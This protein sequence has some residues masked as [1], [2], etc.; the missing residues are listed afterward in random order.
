[1]CGRDLAP[2]ELINHPRPSDHRRCLDCLRIPS[3]HNSS[4]FLQTI[5][6]PLLL[7]FASLLWRLP[8]RHLP[9]LTSPLARSGTPSALHTPP[10]HADS[11]SPYL[12]P[13][14]PTL[15]HGHRN[16]RSTLSFLVLASDG[17]KTLIRSLLYPHTRL[18]QAEQFPHHPPRFP[19]SRCT[20]VVS[21]LR[22]T[23]PCSSSV[24]CISYVSDCT[25]CYRSALPPPNC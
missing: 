25:V 14:P 13:V 20:I 9:R 3:Y 23:V 6:P 5:I 15:Q 19:P 18:A 17:H 4:P 7:S 8:Y 16:R 2:V 24:R 22:V 21:A 10:A 12:T 11:V 1:M